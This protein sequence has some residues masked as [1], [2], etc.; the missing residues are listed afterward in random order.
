MALDCWFCV[1]ALREGSLVEGLRSRMRNVTVCPLWVIL[2][3]EGSVRG[4]EY[5]LVLEY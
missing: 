4:D 5:I 1:L 3:W 2:I